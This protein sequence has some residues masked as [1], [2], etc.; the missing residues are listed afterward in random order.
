MSR[1]IT[2]R[3]RRVST[4][5]W[6]RAICASGKLRSI[7]EASLPASASSARRESCWIDRTASRLYSRATESVSGSSMRIQIRKSYF[8]LPE[9]LARLG[10]LHRGPRLP[11]RERPPAPLGVPV[12]FGEHDETIQGEPFRVPC[13]RVR[14]SGLLDLRP[15]H[16]FRLFRGGRRSWRRCS[17]GWTA[18]WSGPSRR[19]ARWRRRER[20]KARGVPVFT[21][22]GRG[23]VTQSC[24]WTPMPSPE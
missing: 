20:T 18:D 9:I 23:C 10:D 14:H 15:H 1:A 11:R 12:E 7:T 6:A 8:T 17:E 19:D 3:R 5:S 24:S 13:D 2:P 22:R 4:A 16:V 21:G